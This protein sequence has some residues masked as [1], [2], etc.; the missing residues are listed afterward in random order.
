MVG[1]STAATLLAFI[2]KFFSDSSRLADPSHEI[3]KG[4]EEEEG[5]KT[6]EALASALDM[7]LKTVTHREDSAIRNSFDGSAISFCGEEALNCHLHNV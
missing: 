7:S 2:S 1:N 6:V 5:M 3:F 4:A